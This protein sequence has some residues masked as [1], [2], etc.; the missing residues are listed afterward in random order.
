MTYVSNRN[1]FAYLTKPTLPH[2]YSSVQR[3]TPAYIKNYSPCL[4][5][6]TCLLFTKVNL[7]A[8]CLSLYLFCLLQP[9]NNY[10]VAPFHLLVRV[11][12]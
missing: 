10:R 7:F 1:F 8:F 9:E 12:L 2:G 3:D 4:L 6:K 11:I 5:S